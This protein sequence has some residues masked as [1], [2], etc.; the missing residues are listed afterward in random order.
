[1]KIIWRI[2]ME[3]IARRNIMEIYMKVEEYLEKILKRD[4]ACPSE[5]EES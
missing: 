3:K 5:V 1:M 4:L 2:N